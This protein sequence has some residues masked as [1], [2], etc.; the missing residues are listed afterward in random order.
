[1]HF[2]MVRGD[3][4]SDLFQDRGLAGARRRDNEAARAFTQGRDNVDDAG[5]DQ[6][7]RSFKTELLNR[8]DGG[9]VFESDGFHI[10]RKKH[11]VD[12]VYRSEEHTSELQSPC[13]LVC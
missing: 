4:V 5:L 7:R 8:V 3:G 1:M 12:L 6:V 11:L 13:N 10:V 9:E 2:R